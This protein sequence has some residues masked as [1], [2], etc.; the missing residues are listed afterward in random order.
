MIIV[1]TEYKDRVSVRKEILMKIQN[2]IEFG[3]YEQVCEMI[4]DLL[5]DDKRKVALKKRTA[6]FMATKEAKTKEEKDKAW[7]IYFSDRDKSLY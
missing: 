7:R 4:D 3:C 5:D 2:Y 6:L 1:A